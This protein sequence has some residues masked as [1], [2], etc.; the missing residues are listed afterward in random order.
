[1]KNKNFEKILVQISGPDFY[2]KNG[3]NLA[4]LLNE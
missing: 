4:F 1:M 2:P 3:S